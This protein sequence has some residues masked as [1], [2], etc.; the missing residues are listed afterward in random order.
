M[1]EARARER[2]KMWKW[3][4]ERGKWGS[5]KRK[6]KFNSTKHGVCYTTKKI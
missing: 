4:V 6:W 5:N 1:V 2:A 3:K